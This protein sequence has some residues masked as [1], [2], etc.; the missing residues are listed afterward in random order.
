[1]GA[2]NKLKK[3][4]DHQWSLM[5]IL[6]RTHLFKTIIS[7]SAMTDKPL[8]RFSKS[9]TQWNHHTH[10]CQKVLQ[11]SNQSL[12]QFGDLLVYQ[13]LLR[14]ILPQNNNSSNLKET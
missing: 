13:R 2:F 12:T 10:Q 11:C 8:I 9:K 7:H 1:M 14:K 6:I 5:S 4:T 3:F